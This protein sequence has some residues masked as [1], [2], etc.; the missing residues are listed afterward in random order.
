MKRSYRGICEFDDFPG[1]QHFDKKISNENT[2]LEE[3]EPTSS[4]VTCHTYTTR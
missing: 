4:P 2:V 3:K 1:P